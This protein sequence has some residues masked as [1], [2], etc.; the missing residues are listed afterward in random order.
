M[1]ATRKLKMTILFLAMLVSLGLYMG[2]YITHDGRWLIAQFPGFIAGF[3][4]C[5]QNCSPVDGTVAA[6]TWLLISFIQYYVL[7]RVLAW[8]WLKYL[9]ARQ[10][11]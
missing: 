10:S 5:G 1:M 4:L 3:T 2:F 6:V 7:G 9:H 11:R 8:G